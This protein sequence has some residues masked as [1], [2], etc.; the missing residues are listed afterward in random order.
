MKLKRFCTTKETTSKVK[1]QLSDW[2]KII[3]NKATD[4]GL[5]SRF[6][7]CSFL[8]IFQILEDFSD[9]FLLLTLNI[10]SLFL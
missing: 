10:I 9:C 4:K 6:F 7:K 2:E 1:R 8:F 3:G 5:D